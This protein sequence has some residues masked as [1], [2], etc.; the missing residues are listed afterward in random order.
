MNT[1]TLPVSLALLTP[2]N[3][4]LIPCSGSL[5]DG[6]INMALLLAAF[7]NSRLVADD[8][9]AEAMPYFEGYCGHRRPQQ[10][11]TAPS[12]C[13]I[14]DNA[15]IGPV[16][17]KVSRNRYSG[18]NLITSILLMLFTMNITALLTRR[19]STRAIEPVQHVVRD[20]GSEE[21]DIVSNQEHDILQRLSLGQG[22]T[23]YEEIGLIEKCGNCNRL[24]VGSSLR[25]HIGVCC[26]GLGAEH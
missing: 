17:R 18:R 1:S 7:R 10:L 4:C 16:H 22:I 12:R 21:R 25:A 11:S 20:G 5:R 8:G 3:N 6:P 2:S 23:P 13:L 9:Y 14:T 15:T 24:V 19:G 26:E